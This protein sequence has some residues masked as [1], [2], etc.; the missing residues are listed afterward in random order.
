MSLFGAK[1]PVAREC[2]HTGVKQTRLKAFSGVMPFF[3][4]IEVTSQ[5]RTSVNVQ[6][7][8]L[9]LAKQLADERFVRCNSRVWQKK[10]AKQESR[11]RRA[12]S[13]D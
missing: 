4:Q 13:R 9:I 10:H 7:T 12:Q 8:N 11:N 1:R 5:I 2:L 3:V 6:C